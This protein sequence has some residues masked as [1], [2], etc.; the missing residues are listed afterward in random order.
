MEVDNASKDDITRLEKKIDELKV[1]RDEEGNLSDN[2]GTILR[3][4][5]CRRLSQLRFGQIVSKLQLQDWLI[6]PVP[7]TNK[8]HQL[9]PITVSFFMRAF[10]L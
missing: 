9:K 2:S 5:S 1:G 6:E 4:C 10:R 3:N 7:F 8:Q